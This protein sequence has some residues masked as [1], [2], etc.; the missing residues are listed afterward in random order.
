M[1]NILL[2]VMI[3]VL[4]LAS[5]AKAQEITLAYVDFPP[6]EYQE[7]EEAK[8]IQ[9]EIVKT[10]FE[11]AGIPLQLQ[12]APF[13]RAYKDVQEGKIAGLFNFYKTEE[14]LASFD[15]SE[16]II[17]NP[18]V[19]FVKQDSPLNYT[20]QL[21][22]LQGLKVGGILGYTYGTDFDTTTLFT[23]ERVASH[24]INFK[25]LLHDRI[26]VYP[27]DKMVGIY[28]A[29]NENILAE[30]KSLPTPL[31][32]MEGHIGFTKGKYADVLAKINPIIQQ[33]KANGEI[34]QLIER[35]LDGR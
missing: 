7:N 5:F 12:F 19:L 14:R 23:I 30:L 1:K 35:F 10:I 17:A 33:M 21:E 32:L 2:S 29:R 4:C 15:Y 27:C 31:K 8:G 16:P 18:L 11:R 24:E 25:K 13:S 6:Y 34:D 26:D 9:V 28:V 3:G 20:G 22:E